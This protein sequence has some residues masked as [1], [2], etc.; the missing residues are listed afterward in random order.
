MASS[1]SRPRVQPSVLDRLVD[2]DVDGTGDAPEG[3]GGSVARY[4]RSVLRDM[5][6][7]LN[8]RRTP[9]PVPEDLPLVRSSVYRYGLPDLS[10]LSADSPGDRR[11]LLREVRET[12][13]S[14]EPR[15]GD[16]RVSA[17]DPAEASRPEIRLSVQGLLLMEPEPER[18]SFDTVLE[19][20][21]GHF[22]VEE[23]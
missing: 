1:G 9:G 23:G 17:A 12:L 18:V 21:S 5:E 16:V 22:D 2:H 4:K 19:L 20:A 3:W 10:S 6:W 15:L 13:K 8:T 14:Y 7:L 11:L